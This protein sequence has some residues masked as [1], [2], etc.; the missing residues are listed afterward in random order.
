MKTKILFLAIAVIAILTASCSDKKAI[1]IA[2][3]YAQ[4]NIFGLFENAQMVSNHQTK[5]QF[6]KDERERLEFV[7]DI[8][9]RNYENRK[10]L[11]DIYKYEN[12]PSFKDKNLEIAEAV[13]ASS[14]ETIEEADINEG[15]Y[16]VTVGVQYGENHDEWTKAV[17]VLSKDLAVLNK[18]VDIEAYKQA[19]EK[20]L[21]ELLNTR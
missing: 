7:A 17:V 21:E 2:E 20:Q 1:K 13:S 18:P 15:F 3:E 16:V 12:I 6:I 8:S 9:Q 11:S 19:N 5:V 4:N 14:V 10:R